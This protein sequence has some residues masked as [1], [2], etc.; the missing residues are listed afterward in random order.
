MDN[1]LDV[2][3]SKLLSL[4]LHLSL[5]DPIEEEEKFNL[6]FLPCHEDDEEDSAPAISVAAVGLTD[7]FLWG[8]NRDWAAE[9]TSQ[10]SI[11]AALQLPQSTHISP[12]YSFEL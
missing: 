11:L 9:I 6:D 5:T 7:Q 3:F 1:T 10:E 12:F 2:D 8:L 4:S